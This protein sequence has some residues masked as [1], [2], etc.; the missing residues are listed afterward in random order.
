MKNF[1][2]NVTL[3]DITHWIEKEL[4]EKSKINFIVPNPDIDV[5]VKGYKVWVN[6]AELHFCKMTTP[7]KIDDKRVKI[8]F[9]KLNQNHSFRA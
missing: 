4:K 8:T 3:L 9:I 5:K 7:E 6:L 1:I 2:E